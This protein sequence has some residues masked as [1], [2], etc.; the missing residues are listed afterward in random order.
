MNRPSSATPS[1]SDR[2]EPPSSCSRADRLATSLRSFS[3]FAAPSSSDGAEPPSSCS[4]AGRL[5]R[6]LRS[7]FS[8]PAPSSFDRAEPLSSSSSAKLL[9]SL[10]R[11]FFSFA[12]PSSSDRALQ[13]KK[14]SIRNVQRWLAEEP[15]ASCSSAHAQRTSQPNTPSL[16]HRTNRRCGIRQDKANTTE[17]THRYCTVTT[18]MPSGAAD[19]FCARQNRLRDTIFACMDLLVPAR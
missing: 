3:S 13:L 4:S 1:S 7:F 10:L 5:A 17:R 9:A 11:C 6:S 15:I 19:R 14:S 8:S 16:Q 12:A 2:V 18:T